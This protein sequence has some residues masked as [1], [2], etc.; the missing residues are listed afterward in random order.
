LSANLQTVA[1]LT[2]RNQQHFLERL[3][4]FET[5]LSSASTGDQL[6]LRNFLGFNKTHL[7][8]P[9]ELRP[10]NLLCEAIM[11]ALNPKNRSALIG[12]LLSYRILD[13]AAVLKGFPGLGLKHRH[14]VSFGE[15]L[16][17]SAELLSK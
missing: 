14:D 16:Q 3:E 11:T 8:L 10:E 15:G 17:V 9:A 7:H 13:V 5:Y 12:L 6:A 4:T 1:E 2:R